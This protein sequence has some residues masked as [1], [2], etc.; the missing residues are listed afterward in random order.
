MHMPVSEKPVASQAPVGYS[1][2]TPE[3][4]DRLWM[5]ALNSTTSHASVATMP[6]NFALPPPMPVAPVL[7]AF[8][9]P[10][11]SHASVA[12]MPPPI[13]VAPVLPTTRP[14]NVAAVPSMVVVP[15]PNPVA[16]SLAYLLEE[17]A[18]LKKM[19]AA[20]L[21]ARTTDEEQQPCAANL[22][23]NVTRDEMEGIQYKST[24]E[25]SEKL[26]T[27]MKIRSR[28]YV[29]LSAT[30]SSRKKYSGDQQE[31]SLEQLEIIAKELCGLIN[32]AKQFGREF[33][34]KDESRNKHLRRRQGVG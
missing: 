19:L 9:W 27:G 33:V 10:T 5:I 20:L 4:Y 24:A 17:N 29:E 16:P 26:E 25:S 30:I 12:T 7:P 21:A 31:T 13:H 18:K 22:Q 23:P 32:V 1:V 11:T 14:A 15:P 34:V 8:S 3:E 6:S 28:S 2:M